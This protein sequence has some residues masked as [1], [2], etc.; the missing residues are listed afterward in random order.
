M[1]NTF[2]SQS[3]RYWRASETLYGVH[4]FELVRYIYM[5]GGTYAIIV[6]HATHT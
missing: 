4:K 6:M 3:V 2:R 1:T 5:Y